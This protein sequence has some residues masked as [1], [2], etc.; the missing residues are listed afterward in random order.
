MNTLKINALESKGSD[1]Y[2]ISQALRKI[3]NQKIECI[4]WPDYPY[5][6]YVRFQMAYNSHNL[7]LRFHVKESHALAVTSYYNGPVWED[8]C[9]EF[10]CAFDELGDY[11]LEVNC[12][13]VPLLGWT[14]KNREQVRGKER[15]MKFLRLWSTLGYKVPVS[16]EGDV[17][18]ELII[19]M[20]SEIF[21]S[22]KG[23]IFERGMHFK[24]NFYKCGDKCNVPHFVSWKPIAFPEPNFHKPEFFGNVVLE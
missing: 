11:N 10:F 9:C 21:F 24:A 7:F 23:L 20:P 13:G 8:S 18:W 16:I 14:G 1:L 6:P 4:N 15:I 3:P 19:I 22:H 17:E 5:L 12:V 2:E